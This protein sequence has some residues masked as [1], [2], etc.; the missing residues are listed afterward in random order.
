MP[1]KK[2]IIKGKNGWKWG[3]EG[4]CYTGPSG[5]VKAA[6]QGLGIIA[7]G[8]QAPSGERERLLGIISKAKKNRKK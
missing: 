1:I 2:C 3:D 6:R 8:Y 7:S 4:K 5:K